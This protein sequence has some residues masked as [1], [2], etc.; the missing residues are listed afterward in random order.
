M[1]LKSLLLMAR[2][3]NTNHYR[4]KTI[5]LWPPTG[6]A[7][8]A[9]LIMGYQYWPGITL[10]VLPGSPLTGAPFNLVVGMS[11]GNTVEA[12]VAAVT[13]F[14]FSSLQPA[15]VFHRAGWHLEALLPVL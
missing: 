5:L 14:V 6:I 12:L 13:W 1:V 7:L 15:G 11:I 8:A 2:P 9:L 3:P 4:I 10:G